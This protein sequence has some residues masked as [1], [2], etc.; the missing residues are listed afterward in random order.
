M[1]HSCICHTA[2][3]GATIAVEVWHVVIAGG[4]SKFPHLFGPV[5]TL[6]IDGLRDIG[7]PAAG[8]HEE[9]SEVYGN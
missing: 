7:I 6:E 1:W 9:A 2:L 4:Q 5:F 3:E 8:H